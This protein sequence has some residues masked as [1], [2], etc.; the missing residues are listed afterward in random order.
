M[1]RDIMIIGFLVVAVLLS[2]CATTSTRTRTGAGTGAILGGVA[3]ALIDKDN[4]WRGGVVGAFAGALIGGTIG[5]MMD[6]AAEESAAKNRPVQ[7]S[8]TYDDGTREIVRATPVGYSEDGDYKLIKTQVIRGG[9]VVQE[10]V[11]RVPIE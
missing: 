11:K 2:G 10:E 9:V 4:P 7:Y 3:G 8:R 6:R 5:N 1:R